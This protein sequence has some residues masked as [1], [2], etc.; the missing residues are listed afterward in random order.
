[1]HQRACA[2]CLDCGSSGSGSG[3]GSDSDSARHCTAPHTHARA[4]A[5]QE[6]SG[7]ARGTHK[8]SIP[9]GHLPFSSSAL[10]LPPL[11]KCVP[12]LLPIQY[13]TVPAGPTHNNLS[14]YTHLRVRTL[15]FG[16]YTN[17][18]YTLA[19]PEVSMRNLQHSRTCTT[20]HGTTSHLLKGVWYTQL[21]TDSQALGQSSCGSLLQPLKRTPAPHP[22]RRHSTNQNTLS[23]PLAAL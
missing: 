1:M 9:A 18:L 7:V 14:I 12:L 4:L 15:G 13:G 19:P 2:K 6:S 21:L 3:S 11:A 10:P 16:P 22:S 8:L 5:R 20:V 23:A 17:S